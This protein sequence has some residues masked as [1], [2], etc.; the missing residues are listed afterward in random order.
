MI[1]STRNAR[2]AAAAKLK[3]PKGRRDAGLFLLEGP[4]LVAAALDAGVALES[5]F[6][7]TRD[8]LV[9]RVA[10]AGAEVLPVTDPVLRRIADTDNPRGPV[11]VAQLPTDVKLQAADTVVLVGIS[12]P[13]NAGTL[14]RSAAAFEFQVAATDE[15]VDLWS[16]KVLRSGAGSHFLTT[17]ATGIELA[18]LAS[19]GVATVA[20]VPKDDGRPDPDPADGPIA[21]LVGNE[22]HGLPKKFIASATA[23]LTIPT[24]NVESLNAAVAGSIAMFAIAQGR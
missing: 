7:I 19:I 1:S 5:I 3:K 18:D 10:D 14:I 23:T 13:G 22:A 16:P 4:H 24:I 15:C 21:L 20:L 6:A 8:D 11:A 12:D 2:V 17:V 9:D